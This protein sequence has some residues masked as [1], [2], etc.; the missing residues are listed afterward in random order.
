[1]PQMCKINREK[2]NYEAMLT[3]DPVLNQYVNNQLPGG[4]PYWLS[5]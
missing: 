5:G 2:K 4:H 1:M 3:A